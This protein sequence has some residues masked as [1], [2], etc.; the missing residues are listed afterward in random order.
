[1]QFVSHRKLYLPAVTLIAIVLLL[2]VIIAVSTYQMLNHQKEKA[3]GFI[4]GQGEIVLHALESAALT[5]MAPPWPE[6][7][8][9]DRLIRELAKRDDVARIYVYDRNGTVSHAWP[10]ELKGRTASWRPAMTEF[11]PIAV[12]MHRTDRGERVIEMAKRFV[13]QPPTLPQPG[14]AMGGGAHSAVLPLPHADDT[15]VVAMSLEAL[16]AAHRLDVH[17]ALIMGGILL[18]LGSAT[19]FF[20]FVIQNYYLVAKALNRS[21]D[22]LGRVMA[23]MPNG[24]LSIDPDGKITA[25]NGPARELMGLQTGN[26]NQVNLRSM[27][28][29]ADLGIDRTLS[30]GTSVKEK[31]ILVERPD[32]PVSLALSAAPMVRDDSQAPNGGAVII[33]RDLTEIK[34]LEERVR[35]SERL[36]GIGALAAT[37]AHEVRNPLS[38]IRG[39]ARFLAQ[40]LRDRPQEREYAELMVDEVD[41]INKVVTDLLAF[42]HPALPEPTPTDVSALLDHVVRLVEPDAAMRRVTID[43]LVMHPLPQAVI[44]GNQITRAMLNLLLNALQAVA[45]GGTIQVAARPT[46]GGRLELSVADDGPGIPRDQREKIFE[47]FHTTRE[48]GTGLGLAI[49]RAIVEQHDGEVRI[50]S[51]PPGKTRGTL[52]ALQLPLEAALPGESGGQTVQGP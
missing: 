1:M 5:G 25:I 26:L 9:V 14:A 18:V 8:A 49:V 23:S 21:R 3:L 46:D 52:I 38:S 39:F 35:R 22:D 27:I 28:D 6:A 37:V 36:A 34:G 19:L 47:P 43:N 32:G 20:M 51:P 40:L 10:A 44:D 2:L 30:N 4:Q 29:F 33:L 41:R 17:H 45:D 11:A 12:R 16:D 13:S 42:A 48:Q 31:E 15:L 50:D 24:I 7:D